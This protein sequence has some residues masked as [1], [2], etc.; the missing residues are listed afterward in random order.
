MASGRSAG[1]ECAEEK[2]DQMKF[3]PVH[4][5]SGSVAIWLLMWLFSGDLWIEQ[6]VVCALSGI[7]RFIDGI[8]GCAGSGCEAYGSRAKVVRCA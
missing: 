5:I 4:L 1:F 6:L 7:C 2:P 3:N 8:C